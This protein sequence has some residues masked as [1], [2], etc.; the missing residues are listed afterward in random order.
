MSAQRGFGV[1]E[2]LLVLV[3]VA[4]AC[5]MLYQYTASTA[6]TL[7]TLQEQRPIGGA[8]L[9][10]DQ[11]TLGSIRSALQAHYSAQ[12]QW[13]ADK[14]GVLAAIGF[15]PRFQC[16]GNDFDYDPGA[17]QVSLRVTDPTRC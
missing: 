1:I 14:A 6:K 9:V 8:K 12:G 2:I 11:A 3:V 13:P 7:E 10:A 16:P 4:V 17:G 15:H 5:V